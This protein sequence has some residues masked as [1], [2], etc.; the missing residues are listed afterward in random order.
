[1][2]LVIDFFFIGSQGLPYGVR[3]QINF[4][5]H[6]N[7]QIVFLQKDNAF[8]YTIPSFGTREPTQSS[9]PWPHGRLRFLLSFR[10]HRTVTSTVKECW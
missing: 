2:W 7:N 6:L 3:N 5:E 4:K 8:E 9:V 10:A 1:M